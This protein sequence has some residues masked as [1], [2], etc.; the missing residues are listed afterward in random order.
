MT[1][2][3]GSYFSDG[4]TS[5]Q[6]PYFSNPG[7][8]YEGVATGNSADGDNART[9]RETKTAIAAYRTGTIIP[10][11]PPP[12]TT[13]IDIGLRLYDGSQIVQIACEQGTPTS[14][15]RIRKNGITYG[16]ALVQPDDPYASGIIIQTSSGRKAIRKLQ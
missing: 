15:L 3:S 5:T 1:Y 7:V 16:I 8:Q 13:Y 6:V 2:N 10:P 14:Q 4:V 9:I 12:T 11:P